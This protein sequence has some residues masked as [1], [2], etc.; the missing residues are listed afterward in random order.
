MDV[1]YEIKQRIDS[2][3]SIWDVT[4][5]AQELNELC[6]TK[7]LTKIKLSTGF[8]SSKAF[9]V[10]VMDSFYAAKAGSL[11]ATLAFIYFSN[12]C[13]QKNVEYI[14]PSISKNE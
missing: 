2:A 6:S 14:F 9:P 7:A 5:S 3:F 12:P 4:I 13:V 8:D 11:K 10:D 1:L